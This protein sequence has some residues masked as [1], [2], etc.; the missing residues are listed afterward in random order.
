MCYCL[1]FAC[2]LTNFGI[3]FKYNTFINSLLA[4]IKGILVLQVVKIMAKQLPKLVISFCALQELLQIL[5]SHQWSQMFG[6]GMESFDSWS[7]KVCSYT[8]VWFLVSKY[9]VNILFFSTQCWDD[10]EK[11]L[12]CSDVLTQYWAG[13]LQSDS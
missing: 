2:H 6:Q 11:A 5:E 12:S 4:Q 1:V 3:D 7:C 8:P 10:S 13:D 9:S